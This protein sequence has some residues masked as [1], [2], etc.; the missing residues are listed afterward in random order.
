MSVGSYLVNTQFIHLPFFLSLSLSLPCLHLQ[1]LFSNSS[2]FS[3]EK[4]IHV[5]NL[6][7][8][9]NHDPFFLFHFILK[10]L[11]E[12][13]F[14]LRLSQ[15]VSLFA[16]LSFFMLSFFFKQIHI[17]TLFRFFSHIGHYRILSRVPCA[18]Q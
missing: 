8:I 15:S 4:I 5:L 17:S 3:V 12:F 11:Q 10:P 13:D 18:I 6:C 1:A 14:F 9:L 7:F 16:F 2:R